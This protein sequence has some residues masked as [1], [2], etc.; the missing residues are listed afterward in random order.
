M[1]QTRTKKADENFWR[2]YSQLSNI[3]KI[4]SLAIENLSKKR[5]TELYWNYFSR[6]HSEA[7]SCAWTFLC[8]CNNCNPVQK[9]KLANQ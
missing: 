6:H 8:N 2:C 9:V 7:N 3:C 5:L 4:T 1:N